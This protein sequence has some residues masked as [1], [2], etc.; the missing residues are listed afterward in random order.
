[1]HRRATHSLMETARESYSTELQA[2]ARHYATLQSFG[3]ACRDESYCKYVISMKRPTTRTKV[4]LPHY[5]R[6]LPIS[7]HLENSLAPLIGRFL[8]LGSR[9]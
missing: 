6:T 3:S 4:A 2:R 1:M 8:G 9:G 5:S 7:C